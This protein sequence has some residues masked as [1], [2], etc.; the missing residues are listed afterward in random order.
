MTPVQCR[1]P[2]VIVGGSP[3]VRGFNSLTLTVNSIVSSIKEQSFNMSH[4]MKSPN[5]GKTITAI[6]VLAFA[7]FVVLIMQVTLSME[8]EFLSRMTR[9]VL[10]VM[11]LLGSVGCLCVCVVQL[12]LEE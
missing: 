2:V 11:S 12:I 10:F 6:C 3:A 9:L 5:S 4:S 1:R 7:A 8:S